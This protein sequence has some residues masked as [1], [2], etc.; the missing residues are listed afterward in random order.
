MLYQVF[1]RAGRGLEKGRAVVQT[2]QPDHYV[3]KAAAAQDYQL[4]LKTELD[5]RKRHGYPPFTRLIRILRT[6]LD[7]Y[8]CRRK[9]ASLVDLLRSQKE[10]WGMS[11]VDVLGPTPAFPAF[12]RGRYRW[13]VILR[14]SDPR[15]LLDTVE[16]NQLQGIGSITQGGWTVE[17][18]PVMVN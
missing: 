16:I 15:S 14:G 3:I 12:V 5:Y 7:D 18:D 17:V 8:D 11:S 1:G 6:D 9:I 2:F 13:Q 10:A 4:F